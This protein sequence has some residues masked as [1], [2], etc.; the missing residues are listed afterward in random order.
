MLEL[1]LVFGVGTYKYIGG[2]ALFGSA[3][4]ILFSQMM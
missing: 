1:A 3:M 4:P 2:I